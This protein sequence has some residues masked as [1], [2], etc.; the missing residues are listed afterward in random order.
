MFD[1]T[2]SAI[3]DRV[4]LDDTLVIVTADHSHAFAI[5]GYPD[6]NNPILGYST[7][8]WDSIAAGKNH[9]TLIYGAGTAVGVE[10]PPSNVN[11]YHQNF[12]YTAALNNSE[13]R[14]GGEDVL[15]LADGPMAH[16]FQGIRMQTYIAAVM[17]YATC[18]G[19][20]QH[21]CNAPQSSRLPTDSAPLKTLTSF[22]YFPAL[23]LA[24]SYSF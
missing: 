18:T 15:I 2:V 5:T 8:K 22:A 23:L 24:M 6:L 10:R 20:Y 14:H 12:F 11:E 4:N 13:G 9:S 17:Q 3:L 1:K 21:N 7:V 16:L 19:R